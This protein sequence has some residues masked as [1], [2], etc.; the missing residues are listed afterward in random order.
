VSAYDYFG[1][2]IM[3]PLG[4]ALVGPEVAAFGQTTTLWIVA[5]GMFAT[6]AT[7]LAVPSV[8]ALR[9]EPVAAPQ[10]GAAPAPALSR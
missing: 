7:M 4:F 3:Q 2:L 1:S 10:G 9:V 6:T 8:R 5:A